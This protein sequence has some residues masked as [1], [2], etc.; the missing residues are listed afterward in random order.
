MDLERSWRKADEGDG[1]PKSPKPSP[2]ATSD[3]ATSGS[4]C[5]QLTHQFYWVSN[6]F[7]CCYC[8]GVI[9]FLVPGGVGDML[10]GVLLESALSPIPSL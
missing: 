6:S 9:L 10:S 2:D 8:Q 1:Q 7:T 4:C 5:Y 3:P